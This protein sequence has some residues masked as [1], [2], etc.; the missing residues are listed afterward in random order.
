MV[1]AWYPLVKGLTSLYPL[2]FQ[3]LI[4]YNILLAER[5][6]VNAI[7]KY[8]NTALIVASINRRADI[9][10]QLISDDQI[11]V[12]AAN[13]YG[14]GALIIA[15]LNGRTDVVKQLIAVHGINI[16]T[17]NKDVAYNCWNKC[18]RC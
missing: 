18:Q 17:A 3:L 11:D 15:A 1:A 12:N 5:L 7:D 13:E 2:G 8:S 9:V 6:Y 16:N 4:V 14:F 10:K